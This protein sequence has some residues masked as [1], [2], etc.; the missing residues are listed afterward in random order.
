MKPAL[1]L[2]DLQKD[3]L[4]APGLEPAA[5]E[6][7]ERAAAL[8][9]GCRASS[10][11]V[12]HAWTT[13]DR[14]VDNRMPHWRDADR[15]DCVAGTEGH[16]APAPL[17]PDEEPIVE[18]Q[19]FSAFSNPRL[20]ELLERLGA[21]D[22]IV[23]GVHL[24][25]C[26]RSTVL[27]AYERGYRV[28]VAE[29]AVGSYDGLH[30]AVSCRYLE[31]RAARFASVEELLRRL[32]GAPEPWGAAPPIR[33]AVEAAGGAGHGWRARPGAERA[34]I[35]D[36][37]AAAIEA[38]D[39][40]LAGRIV[41]EVGK[42]IRYARSEVRRGAALMRAAARLPEPPGER[43]GDALVR[44][45][46]LG[47]VAQVTPFNNPLAV[48]LGKLAPA[49]RYGN[50]VV[51][52]PSPA[53]L[54]VAEAV[55]E[56]LRDAGIPPGLVSL[57]RGGAEVATGLMADPGIDAVSLTGSS[58]AGFAAQAVCARRRIRLQAELGGNNAAIVWS[59]ADVAAAAAAIAEAGF[60]AAGQRCTANRRVI[61][62]EERHERFIDA[63]ESA[64][65]TLEIGDP[66]DPAVHVG[67][68]V[69]ESA[70]ERVAAALARAGARFEVREVVGDPGARERLSEAGAYQ[71][72][73]L[74]L[75]DDPDAEIVQEES[76]GPVVVVQRASTFDHAL[77]LLN[78]VR[79][80]LVASLFSPSPKL[81]KRFLEEAQAGVLKL[82]RA[83]ADVGVEAPFGG[84]KASG[85]GPPEHG[86][87]NRE[88]YTRAQ[89]VYG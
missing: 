60:G 67:P 15:W 80:G 78:G 81:R 32:G 25:G 28:W 14:A 49:L 48:P 68:L 21:H 9:R 57:A 22:L 4:A 19:W 52:K 10:V 43:V 61:V 17:S 88:F 37:A 64:A 72:P 54:R 51:W 27:D 3:F 35:L 84:W 7:V 74:V 56:L 73:A 24:H 18:K 89:A 12:V 46:A 66:T 53:G 86:H 75:C 38:S 44:R 85:V 2:V 16:G 39:E 6:L 11:P 82:D 36:R 23:C 59:N 40:E 77:A 30:G 50:S 47:T 34:D 55:V 26:V 8:L 70:R 29:D 1:L 62:A 69:S 45:V 13:V 31:G 58:Q 63:L 79:D 5:G 20:A 83:T 65:S 76:F 33:D 42:P 41:A 87:G 71:M